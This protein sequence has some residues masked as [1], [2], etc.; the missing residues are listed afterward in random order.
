MSTKFHLLKLTIQ[1]VFFLRN[2]SKFNTIN[3]V[4][5]VE[6]IVTEIEDDEILV[7]DEH[8]D[9]INLEAEQENIECEDSHLPNYVNIIVF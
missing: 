7:Q 9:D 5:K 6:Q 4:L 8:D 2:N 1:N 3:E